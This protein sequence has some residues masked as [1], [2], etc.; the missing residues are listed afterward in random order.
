MI[1]SD[2]AAEH[3]PAGSRPGLL[4]GMTG[5][6]PMPDVPLRF[7][8]R[9]PSMIV[10]SGAAV[11]IDSRKGRVLAEGEIAIRVGRALADAG[12]ADASTAVSGF[13]LANDVT[14]LDLIEG[15]FTQHAKGLATPIGRWSTPF[16]ARTATVTVTVNGQER[17]S[18]SIADLQLFGAEL[19]SWISVRMPLAA[20]DIVLCGSPGTAA[21]VDPGDVVEIGCRGL[22]PLRTPIAASSPDITPA[23]TPAHQPREDAR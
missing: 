8:C 17:A 15:S 16:E 6:L 1:A 9:H 12:V 10:E 19:L 7:F 23:L 3:A 2:S 13:A 4:L 5:N 18:G 21:L 11:T 20:G 14:Y 22:A